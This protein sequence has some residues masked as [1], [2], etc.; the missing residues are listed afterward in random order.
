MTTKKLEN[1][2]ELFFEDNTYYLIYLDNSE[3]AC[4][5]LDRKKVGRLNDTKNIRKLS[6]LS[7]LMILTL[8]IC[9][10]ALKLSIIKGI[11][12]LMFFTEV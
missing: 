1:Q 5:F 8:R 10:V 6:S 2:S 12:I 7:F 11:L 3:I 9:D 4:L